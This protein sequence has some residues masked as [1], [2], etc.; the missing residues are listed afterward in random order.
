[1]KAKSDGAKWRIIWD[2]GIGFLH[3]SVI[4]SIP[5][6][7]F[8]ADRSEAI[9]RVSRG[10]SRSALPHGPVHNCIRDR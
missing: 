7:S 8:V 9:G 2:F 4:T 5:N 10:D 1:M 6:W 3:R